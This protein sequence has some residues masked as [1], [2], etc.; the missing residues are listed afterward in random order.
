MIS[1][2][3][4][5][6]SVRTHITWPTV[7]YLAAYSVMKGKSLLFILP[8]TYGQNY[9]EVGSNVQDELVRK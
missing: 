9:L 8:C 6:Y 4:G 7:G 1:R 3:S 5:N 2:S